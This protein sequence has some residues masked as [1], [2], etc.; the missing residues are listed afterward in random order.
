MREGVCDRCRQRSSSPVATAATT[1]AAAADD[2][3]AVGAMD[4]LAAAA[5]LNRPDEKRT[6]P[7]AAAAPPVEAAS[8]PPAPAAPVAATAAAAAAAALLPHELLVSPRKGTVRASERCKSQRAA[9]VEKVMT[10]ISTPPEDRNHGLKVRAN[11]IALLA[12]LMHR[13]RA[14]AAEAARAAGLHSIGRMTVDDTV[15]LKAT[16]GMPNKQMRLLNSFLITH[17]APVIAP[18]GKVRKRLKELTTPA[19]TGPLKVSTLRI[20]PVHHCRCH[21]RHC[22]APAALRYPF[23]IDALA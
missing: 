9:A 1:T 14:A 2:D 19:F 17:H 3:D 16:L 23:V 13:D 7:A 6:P 8:V 20:R 18:E 21:C 12:E 22:A 4:A 15:S 5:L 11:R 10:I